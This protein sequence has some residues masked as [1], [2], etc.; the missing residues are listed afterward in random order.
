M[1][2]RSE[3]RQEF[4]QHPRP[5]FQ[6]GTVSV[7]LTLLIAG[8]SRAAASNH[9]HTPT[10]W[11]AVRQ[12]FPVAELVKSFGS[13]LGQLSK[14]EP[15]ASSA[16]FSLQLSFSLRQSNHSHTPTAWKSERQ[17]FPVAKL[18]KSFGRHC[19][20]ASQ[21]GTVSVGRTFFIA[22]VF[23]PAASNHTRT[24]TAWKAVRQCFPVAKLVKSF[25]R[26]SRPAF[27]AATASVERSFLIAAVSHAAA[28]NHTHTPT[29]WKAVRL[30]FP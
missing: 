13:I 20:S 15:R 11:K 7:E 17:C 29:A 16:P 14:L 28:S 12:C 8:V 1:L 5:A 21:A 2:P 26:H 23:L 19:R 30:C 24:P 9:S 6:A 10:A 3:T 4:R 22:A 27:Q 25:G 18:A